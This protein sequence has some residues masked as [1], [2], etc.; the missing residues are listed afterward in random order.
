MILTWQVHY[1]VSG[2]NLSMSETTESG[3]ESKSDQYSG[4]LKPNTIL[5]EGTGG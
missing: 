3:G 1:A 5:K 4:V 2:G